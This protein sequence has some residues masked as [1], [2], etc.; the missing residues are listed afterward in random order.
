MC[1]VT[2]GNCS[3]L[4]SSVGLLTCAIRADMLASC[5]FIRREKKGTSASP[6]GGAM[7]FDCKQPAS[8]RQLVI[9]GGGKS[10][11]VSFCHCLS[12]C[13]CSP[14][15]LPETL[16]AAAAAA[17]GLVARSPR[18]PSRSLRAKHLTLNYS[19]EAAADRTTKNTCL[20]KANQTTWF[21]LPRALYQFSRLLS[22][23]PS[24]SIFHILSECLPPSLMESPDSSGRE[25]GEY[26]PPHVS[27]DLSS[28]LFFTL[29]LSLPL[30]LSLLL[31]LQ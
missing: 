1:A 19:N 27:A 14:L 29:C 24:H 17:C 13:L 5:D 4:M 25:G 31:P 28:C 21:S 30:R 7:T 23:S 18:K 20:P 16:W 8:R 11:S 9:A 15:I 26:P 3:S 2:E 10:L 6:G 12:V 22:V